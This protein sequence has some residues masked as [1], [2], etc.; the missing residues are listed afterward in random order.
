MYGAG[1]AMPVHTLWV[2]LLQ[3]GLIAMTKPTK[4]AYIKAQWHADIVDQ[5]LEGFIAEIGDAEVVSFDM[6]G[7]FEMPLLAKKLA[8]T[9]DYDAIVVAAFVADGG[10]YHHEFVS[11]AVVDALMAAQME[12]EVPMF[13]VSLTPH[14]FQETP[15]LI[16]FYK[17]HFVKKG[18]EAAGA[19][20]QT[21]EVHNAL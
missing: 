4:T 14:N 17:A 11:A 3:K 10:I 1:C 5:S 2:L 8:K 13:S 15:D 6:P 7:A 20:L 18:A 19:V 16:A 9:G 12:T 21:L